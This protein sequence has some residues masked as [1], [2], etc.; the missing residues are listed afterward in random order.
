MKKLPWLIPLF[1]A[2]FPCALSAQTGPAPYLA[3]GN[4]AYAAKDYGT[5]LLNYQAA[6]QSDPKSAAAHQGLG[7]VYYVQG[8]KDQALAEFQASLRLDPN[9]PA[10][11][12]FVQT[13]AN[14][15]PSPNPQGE[16][17]A[18][19]AS[20]PE[21]GMDVPGPTPQGMGD[22]LGVSIPVIRME[23]PAASASEL[24]LP[25]MPHAL[26]PV[27]EIGPTWSSSSPSLSP[28]PQGEDYALG[29]S[30][31][32][33]APAAPA[34]ADVAL[35]FEKAPPHPKVELDV[36]LGGL[37]GLEG[38]QGLGWGGSIACYG[39]VSPGLGLGG[40]L[41]F[42]AMNSQVVS[43]NTYTT[44]PPSAHSTSP[45]QEVLAHTNARFQVLGSAKVTVTSSNLR[46]YLLAGLGVAFI[47]DTGM[48]SE[49]VSG[50]TV[51]SYTLADQ[52]QTCA[53]GEAGVGLKI[54]LA[55][56]LDLFLEGKV[57]LLY[58]LNGG[59]T[60][61]YLPFQAGLGFGL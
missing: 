31:P 13:M 14:P 24:A 35:P 26:T 45:G 29:A 18:L 33:V 15:A 38:S 9:N 51:A 7:T 25:S 50:N 53:V 30:T 43:N 21:K 56:A 27:P 5:A 52:T 40:S 20:M 12:S 6:V 23:V 49:T 28:N 57:N 47:S 41:G 1:L 8:Q 61:T 55:Q 19:G 3:A 22:S 54:P 16:G 46:P 4:Q 10:L 42:Y 11:A 34:A 37:E 44:V 58:G 36:A 39:P 2:A 59:T 60:T 17:Y 48:D 32:E